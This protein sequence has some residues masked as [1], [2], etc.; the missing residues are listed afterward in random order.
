MDCKNRL[1]INKKNKHKRPSNLSK[2]RWESLLKQNA[3]ER[4][5][6]EIIKILNG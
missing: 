4:N 5:Q 2:K 3:E 1:T 6:K